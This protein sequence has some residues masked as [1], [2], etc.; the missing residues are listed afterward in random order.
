MEEEEM[1]VRH[2]GKNQTLYLIRSISLF[3]T[4]AR[5]DVCFLCKVNTPSVSVAVSCATFYRLL[6]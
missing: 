6:V 2:R 3:V 5:A 4:T 1:R